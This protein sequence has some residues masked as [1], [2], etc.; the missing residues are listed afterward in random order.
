LNNASSLKVAVPFSIRPSPISGVGAFAL[1]R[2][3][4]GSRIVEYLGEKIDKRE[5]LR[6]CEQNNQCIF[7]IDD[8]YDLDGNVPW[9]PARFLNHSCEPNC[10]A[11]FETGRIW[12]AAARDIAA[13]DELTFNYGYD[14]IDYKEHPCHCSGQACVGYIVAEEFFPLLRSKA[15]IVTL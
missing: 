15:S 8:D 13:S 11:I 5:S 1:D 10:E 14:L 2:I 9:N 6:R 3:T 7:A 12:I 4:A